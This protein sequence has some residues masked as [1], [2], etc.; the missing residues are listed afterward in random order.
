MDNVKIDINEIRSG[1][2]RQTCWVQTRA[3]VLPPL[4]KAVIT[5]QKLR[6]TGSDIFYGIH[7]MV[8]VDMGQ[9]WGEPVAQEA[10]QA[11]PLE[12][13]AYLYVSDFCPQWH[14]KTQTL[15]GTGHTP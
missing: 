6:L 4:G 13:G 10:F 2:D 8:S 11:R 14:E 7:S 9:T 15:L 3:G 1:Y 5:T 12:A